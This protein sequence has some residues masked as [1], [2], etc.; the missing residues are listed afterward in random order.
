MQ[1]STLDIFDNLG[2]AEKTNGR[3][4]EVGRCESLWGLGESWRKDWYLS[5]LLGMQELRVGLKKAGRGLFKRA[6]CNECASFIHI[7][8]TIAKVTKVHWS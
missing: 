7:H 1:A 5:A 6:L 2:A 3:L 8:T 4:S